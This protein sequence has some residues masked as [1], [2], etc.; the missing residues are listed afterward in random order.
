MLGA[1][2]CCNAINSVFPHAIVKLYT[3][4]R[5]GK[6]EEALQIFQSLN[7]LFVFIRE[8]GVGRTTKAA[9][10]IVGRSFGPHRSPLKPLDAA[11]LDQLRVIIKEPTELAA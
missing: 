5:Q 10:D 3:T 11:T 7:D 9:A 2:G 4:I 8:H 6:V 1:D